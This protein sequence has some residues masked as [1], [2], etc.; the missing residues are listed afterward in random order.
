M[1][2]SQEKRRENLVL[3]IS[4]MM[5]ELGG[6]GI[7]AGYFRMDAAPY[8]TILASTWDDLLDQRLIESHGSHTAKVCILTGHGWMTGLKQSGEI[9]SPNFQ[10]FVERTMAALKSVLNGRQTAYQGVKEI[11]AKANVPPGFVYNFIESHYAELVLKRRGASWY[12]RGDSIK[13]PGNFGLTDV[14]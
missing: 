10:T 8:D 1:S 12:R 4:L 11:A 9:G 2:H 5:Q 3:A 6:R 13:V 7:N 14:G